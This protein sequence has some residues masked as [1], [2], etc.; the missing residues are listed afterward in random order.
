MPQNLVPV[1]LPVPG[2][3][4]LNTQRKAS[5]LPSL[6]ATVATNCVFD[7]SGRLASRKGLQRINATVISGSPNVRGIHEYVD[8]TG[9]KLTILAAGNK[10]YKVSGSTL[11][12]IT[13]SITTPTADNW[14]FVNFNG[15]CVGFQSGHVPIVLATVAGSFANIT[16][17][18][19]QQPTTATTEVLAAFGRLWVMDGTDLKYS[20]SLDETAWNGAFDLT[21]VW[22]A[23]IDVGVAIREFNGYLVIF[24]RN[25]IVVYSNPWVPT[26]GGG[27]DTSTMAL[28]ENIGGVGCL[29]RDSIQEVGKD[30]I[31]LSYQGLRSLGRT[32]QEKS[33]PI[34]VVSENVN[35]ELVRLSLGETDTQI[36]SCFSAS[37]RAYILTLP[38]NG[39]TYYFDMRAPLP[40]G[41]YR[42]T[43]WGSSF[44]SAF[45]D[46]SKTVYFGKAGYLVKYT[47]YLDDVLS[48]GTGGSTFKMDFVSGWTDLSEI[49]PVL[50]ARSKIPKKADL[51][52]L[53]GSGQ[54]ATIKW[55]YD[56]QD[57]FKLFLKDLP[58]ASAAEW[59]EAEWGP[60]YVTGSEDP[61]TL[62]NDEWS[63]G[64]I[65][66]HIKAPMSKTGLVIKLGFSVS[67][68][69]DAVA[70]QLLDFLLKIGRIGS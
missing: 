68:N 29:A 13:G 31:F 37:D 70:L 36:T 30:L 65:F 61:E 4:G 28:I 43:S 24:G 64:L 60:Q 47:G 17:S 42:V 67:I 10:I 39:V 18:G 62:A 48:D 50:S 58:A 8:A 16:L 14:K 26:G 40:D 1:R 32:I 59:G 66:N 22:L 52:V 25:S 27:I 51:L 63:G 49:D 34:S 21:T 7:D 55:A 6:W 3:W 12:D 11:T 35:D 57:S 69:G 54:T 33:M 53:G 38:T 15:K 19:T 46:Q 20:D 56:F 45:V 44:T 9:S 2:S 5:L 23:G 41:T